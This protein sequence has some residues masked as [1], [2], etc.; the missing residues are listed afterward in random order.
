LTPLAKRSLASCSTLFLSSLCSSVILR[1][2]SRCLPG[3]FHSSLQTGCF[4]V[5]TFESDHVISFRL[6]SGLK[7]RPRRLDHDDAGGVCFTTTTSG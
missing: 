5:I 3:Q 6:E 7:D 2:K 1:V 4:A